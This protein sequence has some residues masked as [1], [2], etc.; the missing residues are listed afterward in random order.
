MSDRADTA[1]LH[2]GKIIRG[3]GNIYYL[4]GVRR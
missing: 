3:V 2:V 1:V 4:V